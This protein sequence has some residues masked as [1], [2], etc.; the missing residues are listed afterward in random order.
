MQGH[1][2]LVKE[3]LVLWLEGG[4]K[5]RDDG[6]KNL[7]QLSETVVCLMLIGYLQ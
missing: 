5:A 4:G 7:Q 3:L 1:H 6:G 2:D